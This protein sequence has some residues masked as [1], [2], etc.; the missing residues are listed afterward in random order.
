MI[1]RIKIDGFKSFDTLKPVVKTPTV[2]AGA[3]V[4]ERADPARWLSSTALKE[5]H[6]L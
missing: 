1:I 3:R 2:Y 6:F 4:A 5:L